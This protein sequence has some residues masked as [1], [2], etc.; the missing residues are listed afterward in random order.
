[1]I[2]PDKT[3]PVRNYPRPKNL[4]QLR[5]FLGVASWY[6]RFLKDY[7]KIVESLN[8][9]TR[10]LKKFIWGDEQETAFNTIK[11]LLTEGPMLHRPVPGIEFEI[12]NDACDTG[13]GAV[14]LQRI[15]GV[16]RV[17]SY[18]SIT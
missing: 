13:L 10:K 11:K 6:R 4:R 14:I 5:R 8:N 17:I 7:A 1:M 15:D 16:E 2:D 18:A 3:E 12:H 9:L